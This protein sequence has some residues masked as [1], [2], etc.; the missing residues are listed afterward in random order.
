M[1]KKLWIAL[2]LAAGVFFAGLSGYSA[3]PASKSTKN[4]GKSVSTN[5][6][7]KVEETASGAL[8]QPEPGLVK[9]NHVNVRGQAGLVGETIT[10]LQKGDKVTVLQEITIKKPKADEPARWYKISMPINTPL[11]VS[12]HF[13]DETNH[14]VSSKKLNLRGGPG[15][16]YSIVGTLEK[17]AEL[18]EIRRTN[19][20]VEVQSPTN[21]YAFVAAEFIARQ[22]IKMAEPAPVVVAETKPVTTV[23]ATVAETK[24]E[25]PPVVVAA[26]PDFKPAPSKDISN[27]VDSAPVPETKVGTP[28]EAVAP[29]ALPSST[30]TKVTA[31][32]P[33]RIVQ[34][35]GIVKKALSIQAPTYFEL[36]NE[37]NGKVMNYLHSTNDVYKLKEYSGFKIIVTGEEGL[38]RRWPNT[39]VIE[40]ESLD[41]P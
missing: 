6:V 30:A 14:A 1:T 18:K 25:P 32:L 7:A 4:P 36:V 12:A 10:H 5:K 9:Q 21:A 20:W 41:L 37:E 11:W 40:I 19:D 17:G 39:P 26:V 28:V 8:T 22:A 2:P 23:P 38:D 31:D 33:K 34:R 13:L 35:E 29:L 27:P 16:N 24:P 15:E 3:T